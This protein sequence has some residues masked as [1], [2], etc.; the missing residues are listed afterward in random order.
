MPVS[1]PAVRADQ[2]SH[3][4]K[5]NHVHLDHASAALTPSS[6]LD[7]H[8]NNLRHTLL[9]SPSSLNNRVD[10]TRKRI[11]NFFNADPNHYAVVFTPSA[12]AAHKLVAES[13]PFSKASTLL[14]LAD[15]HQSVVGIREYATAKGA[16][17]RT[18]PLSYDMRGADAPKFFAG[19]GGSG[20]GEKGGSNGSGTSAT[21]V[22]V[23]LDQQVDSSNKNTATTD[24]VQKTQTQTQTQHTHSQNQNQTQNGH[25]YNQHQ[26]LKKTITTRLAN[27]TLHNLTTHLHLPH[28]HNS[29]TTSTST[30]SHH[31][32][33][34]HAH[35]LFAFPAQSNFSGVRHPLTWVRDATQHGWHVLLD[36][37]AYASHTALDLS[38]V[39]PDF[40]TVSF[41]KLFGF[42]TGVA[43]L[44]VRR[45]VLKTVLKRPWMCGRTGGGGKGNSDGMFMSLA[46]ASPFT[47]I[48]AMGMGMMMMRQGECEDNSNNNNNNCDDGDV[49][50]MFE[51]GGLNY[52]CIPAVLLGLDFL[53]KISMSHI[54]HH[55]SHLT[56]LLLSL[57]SSIHWS[58]LSSANP[59]HSSSSLSSSSVSASANTRAIRIYGPEHVGMRGGTI[60]FDVVRFGVRFDARRIYDAA[61]SERI[62]LGVGSFDNPGALEHALDIDRK[63]I[64]NA[65][66]KVRR[67][68]QRVSRQN[69]SRVMGR[70]YLG[71]V[72]VSVG[73]GNN[74]R[75]VRCFGRFIEGFVR[76]WESAQML[77]QQQKE[78]C[79]GVGGGGKRSSGNVGEMMGMN[80]GNGVM[81][82]GN[83]LRPGSGKLNGFVGLGRRGTAGGVR[84]ASASLPV[85]PATI[86]TDRTVG[87][88]VAP[89]SFSHNHNTATTSGN[90][91]RASTGSIDALRTALNADTDVTSDESDDD[92]DIEMDI[93]T[94]D[95]ILTPASTTTTTTTSMGGG[96]GTDRKYDR[97]RHNDSEGGSNSLSSAM[98]TS[99]RSSGGGGVKT[100]FARTGGTQ[101]L[102]MS[103]SGFSI[104][105]EGA[106]AQ[107]V[108]D[109]VLY[110][111][112]RGRRR[113]RLASG[114]SG[115]AIRWR[116][117]GVGSGRRR[118][119][120]EEEEE[121]G[122]EEEGEGEA[123]PMSVG[124]V[125]RRSDKWGGSGRVSMGGGTRS[126]DGGRRRGRGVGG[127]GLRIGNLRLT[128][129]T[130]TGTV[131]AAA[132][133][134]NRAEVD[135]A[136]VS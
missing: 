20:G 85:S 95:R 73:V 67:A 17:V 64:A 36:A 117:V 39:Q 24:E 33:S 52:S 60:S 122:V 15:N 42:P 58:L 16:S 94:D 18:V 34:K 82:A 129:T 69:V 135:S 97:M 22:G 9:T 108:D 93:D 37:T 7:V 49:V 101:S 2:F 102:S 114:S 41:Y 30:S 53:H 5:T 118:R 14:L 113:K 103:L 6:L 88:A 134:H 81:R 8:F 116:S 50:K 92:I 115:A 79:A 99:M 63:S 86:T 40:V 105:G 107:S 89:V 12:S 10:L 109:A 28:P 112:R 120:G 26:N 47:S 96:G 25:T 75:D 31:P 98:F 84:P 77:Q 61:L 13:F 106:K 19:G 126:V 136:S 3:L 78:M 4:D 1:I 123:V 54:H 119:R 74:E 72:R 83:G 29:S 90:L 124:D 43:A 87:T 125:G 32:I 59:N 27:L 44:I 111:D 132:A 71:C 104:D 131:A 62:T 57:L 35:N 48:G 55:V 133:E 65:M 66:G 70:G 21:F 130:T 56:R 121:E 76:K 23:G 128:T 51:D 80:N 91:A 11:L 46:V 110:A 68:K 127:G 45:T 38:V 100:G